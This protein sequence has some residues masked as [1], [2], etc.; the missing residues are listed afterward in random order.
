MIQ[1]NGAD[2]QLRQAMTCSSRASQTRRNDVPVMRWQVA[3]TW[4][5]VLTLVAGGCSTQ[6]PPA[7]DGNSDRSQPSA[8]SVGSPPSTPSKPAGAYEGFLETVSCDSLSGWAWDMSQPESP[9]MIDLYD[10]DRLVATTSAELFRQDLLE[11]RK[12]NGRHQ[13]IQPTPS[14][15]KNGQP[16]SLRAL[17]KGTSFTL[18]RLEGAPSSIACEPS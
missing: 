12:G 8:S 1:V 5:L 10:G 2:K 6:S 4:T 11:A 7:G 17:V 15:I 3:M 13:F 18:P 14:E 9:L 16:H